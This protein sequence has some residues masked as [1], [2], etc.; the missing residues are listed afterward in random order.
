MSYYWCM[1]ISTTEVVIQKRKKNSNSMCNYPSI[2]ISHKNMGTQINTN[3]RI[4]L[5]LYYGLFQLLLWFLF[6]EI[7]K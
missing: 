7:N 6:S 2:T 4:A 5:E 3:Q 1:L